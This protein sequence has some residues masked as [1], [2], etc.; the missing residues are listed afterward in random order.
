M[1]RRD[2]LALALA[3]TQASHAQESVSHALVG[4]QLIDGY[5]GKPVEDSV[6]LISGERVSAVGRIGELKVP[7]GATVVPTEGLT[8]LPGLSDLYVQLSRLGHGDSLRW[9]S[10]YL[11]IA[12][13]VVT[14]VAANALL[15]A[16]VT[17]VRDVA[18]PLEAAI[19]VRE[20]IRAARIPGPT[21]YS[22]GPVLEHDPPPE[23][24]A[25]RWGVSGEKEA[26]ER[27]ARLAAAGVDFV[28]VADVSH[29]ASAELAAIVGAAHEKDLPVQAL[30]GADG[31]IAHALGAGVDGLLS[32]GPGADALPGE[33]LAAFETRARRGTPAQLVPALAPVVNMEWL[34]ENHAPLDDERWRAGLPALVAE[35]LRESLRD[36]PA[37]ASSYQ[38]LAQRRAAQGERA[39]AARDAGAMLLVGSGAGAPAHLLARATWQEIE[40]WVRAGLATPMEAIRRATYWPAVALGVPHESGAVAPGKYADIIAV[41]GDPLRHVDRLADVELVF[42]RGARRR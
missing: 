32:L 2:F 27:V 39:R 17:T 15:M 29:L 19:D 34:I 6:V 3:A 14:P 36:L 35:E 21:V 9:D 7:E 37:V 30:I 33:A 23:V 1:R 13:R 31:E 8:V 42:R 5:G 20:R 12:E 26:R 18:T 41:R 25:Y 38:P 10:A 4:G 22:G 24:H 11:P 16:G 28:T 40:A